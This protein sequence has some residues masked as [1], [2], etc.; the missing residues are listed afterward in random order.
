[1]PVGWLTWRP[2]IEPPG[3]CSQ[4]VLCWPGIGA[5]FE[6]LGAAWCSIVGAGVDCCCIFWSMFL[7]SNAPQLRHCPREISIAPPQ[8][9][10]TC[11]DR[12]TPCVLVGWYCIAGCVPNCGVGAGHPAAAICGGAGGAGAWAG[13][14]AIK[15]RWT[16]LACCSL[17]ERLPHLG[18][19][20]EA[21]GI[22]APQFGHHRVP[23]LWQIRLPMGF[24]AWH[25][26]HKTISG[27]PVPFPCYLF[28]V[29]FCFLRWGTSTTLL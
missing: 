18:Q 14:E 9:G 24:C 26:G 17:P 20:L 15:V 7:L 23:H 28:C 3:C 2:V 13:C 22:D 8:C 19:Y 25:L 1:M 4:P 16:A 12:E 29:A 27:N 5:G 6:N 11:C 21:D 10:Q